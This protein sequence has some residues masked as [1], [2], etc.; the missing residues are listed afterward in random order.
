MEAN[1]N[2]VNNGTIL[3]LGGLI[4]LLAGLGTAYLLIKKQEKTGQ[5]IKLTSSDGMK[6][7]MNTFSLIKLISDIAVKP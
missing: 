2:E 4:G 1:E 5:S 6:L 7:G 3:L